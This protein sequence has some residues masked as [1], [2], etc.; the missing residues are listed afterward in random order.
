VGALKL[1]QGFE[2]RRGSGPYALPTLRDTSHIHVGRPWRLSTDIHVGDGFEPLLQLQL[3]IDSKLL[4]KKFSIITNINLTET[5][6]K[7][8]PRKHRILL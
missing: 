3:H 6:G 7:R 2:T 8:R 5:G 4:L 1:D